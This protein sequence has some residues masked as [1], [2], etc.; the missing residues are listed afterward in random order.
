VRPA[1]LPRGVG[2]GTSCPPH[3]ARTSAKRL[4]PARAAS[5]PRP[6]C[7]L[8]KPPE[9][10]DF[11]PPRS[12]HACL[13]HGVRERMMIFIGPAK[14]RRHVEPVATDT[15]PHGDASATCT[16]MRRGADLRALQLG[17]ASAPARRA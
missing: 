10:G 8:P 3:T 1:H 13:R 11:P 14:S 5:T 15:P 17:R 2:H 9:Q 16:S 6:R 4:I 12:A 7:R